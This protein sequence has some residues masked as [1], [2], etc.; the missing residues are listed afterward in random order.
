MGETPRVFLEPRVSKPLSARPSR[1]MPD[2]ACVGS[3]VISYPRDRCA[4]RQRPI[5]FP[6][7]V[8]LWAAAIPSVRPCCRPLSPSLGPVPALCLPPTPSCWRRDHYEHAGRWERTEEES[9]FLYVCVLHATPLLYREC[10]KTPFGMR[11][12]PRPSWPMPLYNDQGP[13]AVMPSCRHAVS[14]HHVVMS[15][16]SISVKTIA[17]HV[18]S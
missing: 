12:S 14:C 3:V 7:P 17:S 6:G 1:I 5:P 4:P 11:K 8:C 15:S 16:C 9:T 2:W 13:R 10:R 18:S